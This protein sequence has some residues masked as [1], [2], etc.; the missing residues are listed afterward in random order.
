V[1]LGPIDP[2]WLGAHRE[3][4]A[5]AKRIILDFV[6]NHFI[7]HIVEKKISKDMFGTLMELFQNYCVS[8]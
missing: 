5:R 6:E 1:I 2:T 3:K 8:R 4:Q 7:S